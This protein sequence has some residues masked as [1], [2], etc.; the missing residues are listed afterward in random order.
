MSSTI[1][2][3]VLALQGAFYEHIQLF[4]EASRTIAA[5]DITWNFYEVRTAEELARSDALVIPGGESTTMSLVA[6]R[7]GILEALREYVKY[8]SAS[9]LIS[10][11]R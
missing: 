6:E 7:S 4:K 5:S 10:R 11:A 2:I 8:A 3:G 9:L 1:N